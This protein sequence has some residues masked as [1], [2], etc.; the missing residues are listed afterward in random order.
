MPH[1]CR[2][3]LLPAAYPLSC[4]DD[5]GL[6]QFC[7][8]DPQIRQA[9]NDE[10]ET[11]RQQR[12]QDLEQALQT[13]RGQGPYD[14][15][16]CLSGGKDSLYLLY[17]LKEHYK[18]N[19]LAFTTDINIPK[20]AWDNIKTALRTLQIDH[21][22]YRP[23]EAFYKK[24]FRYVLQNQEERGAV[25]SLSYVYAP[26]FEGDALR[27]A[28]DK[29]IPLVLAAYSPGQPEKE[30]MV[31][32]FDPAFIRDHHWIPPE[33][34]TNGIFTAEDLQRFWNPRHY[35]AGTVFPR[36]IAPFHAW[37]Y[38]QDDVMKKVYQLK[39]V[40]KP[41]FASPILSNYPIN[42]LLMY[43]DLKTFGYNPYAPEF[44]ALIR[45]G[46]ANRSY[47]RIMAPIVNFMIR[48]MVFL[49]RDARRSLDWL[50]MGKDELAITR[51]KCAYDP[52]YIAQRTKK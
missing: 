14:V 16:V 28:T 35:P 36:Y 25:Y 2:A 4:I 9:K 6:C 1:S 17:L 21:V 32:E 12:A 24:L 18:L 11:L 8:V 52:P 44:A 37:P 7:R 47:W 3:C 29:K 42:W 19:V 41:H 50:G 23:N 33:L 49:G 31:Y 45:T 40:R 26:L 46:K 15:L 39:L 34:E 43:S 38:D 51:S 48:Q 10:E 22:V 27:L 5:Q 20:I 13:C 30:R